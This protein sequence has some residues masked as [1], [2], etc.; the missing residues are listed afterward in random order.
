MTA[1][2]NK[3]KRHKQ[4]HL[5]IFLKRASSTSKMELET[6]IRLVL[7]LTTSRPMVT[8]LQLG[9]EDNLRDNKGS[10]GL[11]DTRTDPPNQLPPETFKEMDPKE[12]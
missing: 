5:I 10:G 4:L 7:R 1:F 3:K 12:L 8:T 2:G 6:G 9:T 11:E